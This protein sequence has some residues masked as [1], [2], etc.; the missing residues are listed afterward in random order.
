MNI[1]KKIISVLFVVSSV[2][3]AQTLITVNETKITKS[4]VESILMNATQGRLNQLSEEKKI[5]FQKEVLQQL[6]A[7]VLIYDDAKKTGVLKSAEFKTEYEKVLERVKKEVAIQ[8]WQKAQFD[9]VTVS[10]KELKKYYDTN[11]GEFKEAQSVHARHILVKSL[12]EAEAILKDLKSLKSAALQTKFIALAKEKSVGP[13]SVSGGDLGI[14]PK[15]KMV[16]E[17]DKEVFAMKV[18]TISEP[19]K[20]QFG[21]HLIYLEAKNE[22]KNLAFKEVKAFIEQRL[23]LEKFKVTMKEKME[24][25]EKKATIK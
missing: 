18:G 14:F 16:P 6:I 23:K 5:S 19:V 12:S 1:S 7:K 10:D 9:K 15:G 4:D 11:R 21:F 13:S 8:I 17:F 25:L 22:A 3:S 20:T 24:N 2:L